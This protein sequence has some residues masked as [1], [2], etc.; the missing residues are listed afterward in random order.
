M[1][2]FKLDIIQTISYY[3]GEETAQMYEKYFA[4]KDDSLVLKL[5]SKLLSDYVGKQK[6]FKIIKSISE[7]HKMALKK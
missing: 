1:N 2:T 5:T 3:F 4:D 6:A 7:S